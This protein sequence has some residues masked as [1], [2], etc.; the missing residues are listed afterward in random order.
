MR[1]CHEVDEFE[2]QMLGRA[3]R[4]VGAVLLLPVGLLGE[5]E[6]WCYMW[7]LKIDKGRSAD[8]LPLL[9]QQFLGCDAALLLCS[10]K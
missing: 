6:G 3:G 1:V 8:L 10:L 4:W 9:P 2:G 5:G 7:Q